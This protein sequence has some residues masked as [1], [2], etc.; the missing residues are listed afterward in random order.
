MT[1]WLCGLMG[2][3]GNLMTNATK[4]MGTG[5]AVEAGMGKGEY[6][7]LMANLRASMVVCGPFLFGNV[8]YKLGK[9]ISM[10]GGK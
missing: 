4:S 5:L 7:G 2:W 6:S 8:A 1:Q 10:P 9:S 3:Y